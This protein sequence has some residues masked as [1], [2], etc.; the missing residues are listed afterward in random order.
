MC[1]ERQVGQILL[2]L[3]KNAAEA[4]EGVV[5]KPIINVALE[6]GDSQVQITVRDNGQGFPP[7]DMGKL[8]EP[9][10]TTRAKG[11]GLGLA[12]VKKSMEDHKGRVI[13]SNHPQ[14]GA[15]VTLVFPIE[16]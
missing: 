10:V 1:D 2:N 8:T 15:V 4:M 6:A 3:M 16:K 12:I 11:T 7:D 5:A 13:L 14:G 9:Y